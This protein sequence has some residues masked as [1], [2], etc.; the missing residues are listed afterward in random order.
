MKSI[1]ILVSNDRKLVGSIHNNGIEIHSENYIAWERGDRW[2]D[3][4]YVGMINIED[5]SKFV[6]L[7]NKINKLLVL[8]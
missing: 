7:V 3:D 6:E 8:K 4:K 1:E 5:W 2:Y